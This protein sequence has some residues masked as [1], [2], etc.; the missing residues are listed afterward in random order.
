MMSVLVKA[1]TLPVASLT[2]AMPPPM[3][4][5]DARVPCVCS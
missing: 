5:Q 4:V 2:R 3:T 1:K